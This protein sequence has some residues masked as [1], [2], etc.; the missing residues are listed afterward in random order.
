M[1]QELHCLVCAEKKVGLGAQE[2]AL[3]GM[4]LA[5]TSSPLAGE[6]INH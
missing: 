4:P 5:A 2:D 1:A 3:S 6:W